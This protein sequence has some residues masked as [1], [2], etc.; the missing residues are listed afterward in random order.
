MNIKYCSYIFTLI[1]ISQ[2]FNLSADENVDVKT[3]ILFLKIQELESE[4][5]ELRNNIESQN[6]LIE[7]LI[8]ESSDSN[9]DSNIS[10]ENYGDNIHGNLFEA[11]I[12]AIFLDRGYPHCKKFIFDRVINPHVNLEKLKNKII[13]YKSLFIEWCQ[14]NKKLYNY[15]TFEDTGKDSIK[16][17]SVKLSIDDKVIAKARDTSKKKAEEKASKRAFFMFQED[18]L[19]Y[20]NQNS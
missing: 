8:Q 20:Q 15:E 6:Y 14:K 2:I 19:K 16:H 12:G 4:I 13:S 10:E 7:K 1:L 5:A 3:D 11:L 17:F 18:I 9:V